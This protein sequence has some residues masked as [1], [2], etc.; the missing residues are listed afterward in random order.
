MTATR[1][2]QKTCA[3]I[4]PIYNEESCIGNTLGR[5]RHIIAD[6]P[7]Y[8][9][10]IICVDDG[11]YD[12]SQ[13]ILHHEPGITLL[14]HTA[15]RGYGAALRTGLD[16]SQQEWAF[17]VDAD[18]TYELEDLKHLLAEAQA[19]AD[20]VV[21]VREGASIIRSPI[22]RIA[23]W[24][25]RKMVHGLTGVMVPD[26]NSG[27]RL[28]RR[29]LYQEFR[30]LLPEGFSFTTTLTVA[31]LYSGYAVRYV[32]T[33]YHHRVGRSSIKP[34]RDFLG[35]AILIIRLASYFEPLRFFLPL[36]IGVFIIAVLRG[37]RDLVVVNALGSLSVIMVLMA[38]QFFV[39]G[40]ITDAVVR[41]TSV[42][43]RKQLPPRR[44]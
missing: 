19:G 38:I 22:R 31:S 24:L 7:D 5:I 29:S 41:R 14:A 13:E 40:V 37:I 26:L 10:E 39:L 43:I 15:N 4:V 42:G 3:I 33:H 28:F 30:H 27:M 35:F 18:G 34:L 25:L 32:L 21:G 2:D 12:S 20:M 6:V 1:Q 11:S 8:R 23:L 16:Y 9:F 36:S 17:I 44:R